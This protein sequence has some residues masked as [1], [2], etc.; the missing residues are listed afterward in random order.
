MLIISICKVNKILREIYFGGPFQ[1]AV[2]AQIIVEGV[3]QNGRDVIQALIFL[4]KLFVA[5]SLSQKQN[6]K[7]ENQHLRLSS[8]V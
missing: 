6:E 8:R 2:F 5:L 1:I 3:T 7:G 4:Q